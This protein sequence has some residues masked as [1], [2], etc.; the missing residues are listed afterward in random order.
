MFA[1]IEIIR[2][3]NT[4]QTSNSRENRAT[5]SNDLDCINCRYFIEG[6]KVPLHIG[7]CVPNL[8]YYL[9]HSNLNILILIDWQNTSNRTTNLF[10]IST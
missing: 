3:T 9:I 10:L 7:Y 5:T 8:T 1:A 4:W 2:S 6:N